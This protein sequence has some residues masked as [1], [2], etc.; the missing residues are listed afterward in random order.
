[1]SGPLFAT[2]IATVKEPY[3]HSGGLNL[4]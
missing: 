4:L 3:C 1:V 2:R